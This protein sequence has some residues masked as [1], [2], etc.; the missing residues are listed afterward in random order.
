MK[1]YTLYGA[2]ILKEKVQSSPGG[3][4]SNGQN[5]ENIVVDIMNNNVQQVEEKS[6]FVSQIAGFEVGSDRVRFNNASTTVSG[7][8]ITPSTVMGTTETVLVFKANKSYKV[9]L[10]VH[11]LSSASVINGL[12]STNT[13][14]ASSNSSIMRTFNFEQVTTTPNNYGQILNMYYYFKPTLDT[15]LNITFPQITSF[16]QNNSVIEAIEL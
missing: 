6:F 13:V 16:I 3:N 11:V 5:F 12:I 4:P 10:T 2:K 8:N 15:Y 1:E 7:T 14:S 9:S